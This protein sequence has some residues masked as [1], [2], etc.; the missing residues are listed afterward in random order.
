MIWVFRYCIVVSVVG[1]FLV[2]QTVKC[3]ST[4]QERPGFNSGARGR[5]V[6]P[7]NGSILEPQ[8]Q[9]DSPKEGNSNLIGPKK[10]PREGQLDDYINT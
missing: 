1:S 3:L 5:K 9:K 4:M 6:H 8:R 2:V 7:E 10:Y